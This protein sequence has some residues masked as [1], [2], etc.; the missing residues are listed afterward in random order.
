MFSSK[1]DYVLK[2]LHVTAETE[3]Q[4]EWLQPSGHDRVARV[5][6]DVLSLMPT[7]YDKNPIPVV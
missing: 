2:A 5:R 3:G 7:L 6:G 4:N 1:S